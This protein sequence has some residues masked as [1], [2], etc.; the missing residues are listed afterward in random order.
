MRRKRSDD[1]VDRMIEDLV[2][3]TKNNY[4]TQGVSFNKNKESHMKLLR[5]ALTYSESFS[6]LVKDL[7]DEKFDIDTNMIMNNVKTNNQTT[8]EKVQNNLKQDEQIPPKIENTFKPFE[9]VETNKSENVGNF[10]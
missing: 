6:G 7:I 10:L 4:I 1:E 2:S 5:L 8:S 3:K 9:K